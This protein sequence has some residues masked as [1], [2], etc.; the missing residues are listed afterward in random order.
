M[1][2]FPADFTVHSI[3]DRADTLENSQLRDLRKVLYTN[4]NESVKQCSP[5]NGGH[6][7]THAQFSSD[8]ASRTK[9]QLIAELLVRDFHVHCALND[10]VNQHYVY[11]ANLDECHAVYVSFDLYKKVNE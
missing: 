2:E 6:V 10:G 1:E 7:W 11:G 5:K 8:V 9:A 4:V 3:Q